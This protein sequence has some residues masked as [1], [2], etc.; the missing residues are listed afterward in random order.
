MRSGTP[1]S[2]A[3]PM[4]AKLHAKEFAFILDNS[5]ARL[6]FVTPD[7]AGNDRRGRDARRRR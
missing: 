4:N 3:V 6:C 7:L 1:A 2:C 5:G